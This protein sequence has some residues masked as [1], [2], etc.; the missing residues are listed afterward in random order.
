MNLYAGQMLIVDLSK[1]SVRVEPLRKEWVRDYWGC[2]GLALRYYWDLAAPDVD[3]LSPDNALVI[4]TGPLS[5]TL[6]PMTSRFCLV[7]KS[8]YTGT[9]FETNCGGSF[10]PVRVINDDLKAASSVFAVDLDDDGDYDLL[11]ASTT[12]NTIGWY[13]NI[14]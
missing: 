3:P 9:I 4:M 8:P 2:W 10:G 1:K 14:E 13:E 11:T 6:V 5:G 12:D 7:S